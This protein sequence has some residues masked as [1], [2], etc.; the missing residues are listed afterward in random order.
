MIPAVGIDFGTTN[1]AI[2]TA[3]TEGATRM[4][5][6]RL[7]ERT[8]P[9]CR[10][11]IF[12]DPPERAGVRSRAWGGPEAIDRYLGAG[13]RGRLMQSLKSFLSSRHM[14]ATSVFGATYTL[15]QLI[16]FILRAL[17]TA[18][19]EQFGTLPPRVVVGR[20]VRFAWSEGPEDDALAEARLQD[21]LALAGFDD[22]VFELEPVGAAYRYESLLDH[23]ETILVADLG[24]GT[25]DF[26]LLRVGPGPRAEGP[27]AERVIAVSGVGI[28]GDLFDAALVRNLVSPEL[29]MG[30]EYRSVLGK[31]L[32]N[33]TWIYLL[34]EKWHQLSILK[35]A[36]N[37]ELL[38][39]LERQAHEPERIRRLIDIVEHDLG[40][41][42]SS[43]VERCKVDLTAAALAR[44]A[45]ASDEV[46]IT[47]AATRAAFEGWIAADLG[48][49]E[50]AMNELLETSGAAPGDVDGVFLTGGSAQVPAVRGL[51]ARRFGERR[52]RD[53]DY[54]L[55]V[56]HGLA[57]RARDLG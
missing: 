46:S 41:A 39:R 12:F 42:L 55:S 14:V 26:C 25:S 34:L 47:A 23:D 37:R 2:A 50:R 22:V 36:R 21:A 4:A 17:R 10:S 7:G 6:F 27:T 48:S 54:L 3:D 32:P 40:Y 20:P 56:A 44:L 11:V 9:V 29:G 49:V 38:E 30:A 5:T 16:A 52:L 53:G 8:V 19:E 13:G 15:E 45:F 24:G 1:S 28:G 51:L 43:A 35:S 57:L 18:A 31:E 33:P